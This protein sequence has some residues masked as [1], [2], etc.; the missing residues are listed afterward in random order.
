MTAPNAFLVDKNQ[1]LT[2]GIGVAVDPTTGVPTMLTLNNV[3][4]QVSTAM[5][6]G[7]GVTSFSALTDKITADIVG[8]N[9]GV[10]ALSTAVTGRVAVPLGWNAGTNTPTL[11]SGTAAAS[12]SYIV[13]TPG[14]TAL[15]GIFTWVVGDVAVFGVGGSSTWSRLV[16]GGANLFA[17]LA[18]NVTADIVSINTSVG[19]IATA[20][21]N[22]AT[23]ATSRISVPLGW[24]ASTNV[25]AL[26]TSTAPTGIANAYVVTTA[27][28]TTLDG[29]TNW[30]IGDIA[31]FGQG[32]ANT[33]SRIAAP[34]PKLQ[35]VLPAATDTFTGT[36]VQGL[37]AA[38]TITLWQAVGINSSGQVALAGASNGILCMG[39]AIAGY[40]SS[41]A[42]EFLNH[43]IARHDAW[44][45]TPGGLVYM[46]TT[47]G[48]LTQTLPA[49]TGNVDQIIGIALSA[50]TVL[51][52]VGQAFSQVHA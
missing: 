6:G 17:A 28:T 19:N 37:V 16:N 30:A 51:V 7:G 23:S 5:G 20:A 47:A 48:T 24:N 34:V 31:L 18:D 12:N 29:L 15:D 32:G 3:G 35:L 50:T 8:T 9:T 13:T 11:T 25:P 45:W 40:A 49:A 21:A 27:G 4:A 22:A 33:W 36:T 43:G 14:S 1:T 2:P 26:V 46:S 10:G 52:N 39:L 38:A 42:T 44:T 41:A